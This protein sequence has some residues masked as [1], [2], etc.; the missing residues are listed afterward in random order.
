MPSTTPELACAPG[1]RWRAKHLPKDLWSTSYRS[2]TVVSITQRIAAKKGRLPGAHS[3]QRSVQQSFMG[4]V[5][6]ESRDELRNLRNEINRILPQRTGLTDNTRSVPSSSPSDLALLLRQELGSERH[7]S[8]DEIWSGLRTMV[9]PF[10]GC[11]NR[12]CRPRT[13]NPNRKGAQQDELSPT[14]FHGTLC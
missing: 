2:Q 10:D 6:Y 4:V 1:D 13:V 7:R 8:Y 9:V 12:K 3:E 5:Q 14:G 11:A